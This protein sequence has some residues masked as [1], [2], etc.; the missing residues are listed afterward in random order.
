MG[1]RKTVK[2]LG[3][4]FVAAISIF[5]TAI[6]GDF[7]ITSIKP[8]FDPATPNAGQFKVRVGLKSNAK[9]SRKVNLTCLYL[10]LTRPGAY[11]KGE[12]Q[13][14]KQYQVVELKP[15]QQA[16]IVLKNKFAAWHPETRGELVV[17][18]VGENA[19][20]SLL[21]ETQFRPGSD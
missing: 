18:L 2:Q 20:K 16:E 13:I 5:S 9:E 19:A 6:A 11:L 3:A 21:V 12:P 17:T 14:Q 4:I 10:G 8:V 1:H 15:G 7:A